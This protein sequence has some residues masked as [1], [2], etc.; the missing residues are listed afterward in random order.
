MS[1]AM[2]K[3]GGKP[4]VDG[5]GGLMRRL[6]VG[7]AVVG[8]G[9]LAFLGWLVAHHFLHDDDP[10]ISDQVTLIT[11]GCWVV[12]FMAGIGAF[13]GP[14]KWVLGRD[15]THED[16]MFLAG[17]DQ[18]VSR[19]FRFTT[20]HKVVGIQYLIVT[21]VLLAVGGT[22]AMMIRTDLI[23]PHSNFLGPQT[24]NAVVG[25]H[26]IIMIIATIV[27]VTG[28]FGNFI[29]PIMIGARDMAFPRLNALSLWL[30]VA[31]VPV[32]LSAAFLGGIPTG[33]SAYSPLSDQAPP[34]M[35]SYLVAIV[36][37]AISSA[38]A[39]ANITTTVLTMRARGMTWNRTPIF[40]YGTVASVGLALPALPMFMSAQVLLAVDRAM[41]GQFYVASG[42]GSPWLYQN[43]F[44]LFGHPEVYVIVIPAVVALME[45]TPVFA[46]KPLYN[47]NAAVLGIVGIVGL[48][49]MVWAHHMYASGWAPD[50]NGPFMLTTELISVPTGV[51]FLVVIGTIWRGRIWTTVPMMAVYA[52]LWN[53]IIGGVT[54]IYLSDVPA[55]YALHGSMFVTAHF[56]YTLMGAGLTGAIGALFYWFPKMTGRM[57]NERLAK[58]SFWTVQIGFNVVFLGMFAV[59]L[60]GQP[61]RVFTYA[62][63]FVVGNFVSSIGAYV[64]G[65][66][67]LLM[68]YTVI[69][70]WRNG[71]IAPA[72]PWGAKSLEWA[73][74][75]PIPLSNFEVLPVVVADAYGYGE[76][77][78][79]PQHWLEGPRHPDPEKV[80]AVAGATTTDDSD[81][82]TP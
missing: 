34:G 51:L 4:R 6:N 42:G 25:L 14:I 9:V 64:I 35:D 24:Y 63:T 43:L 54:G 79:T 75:N 50:L 7:S 30:L 69:S 57:Y 17:K 33:W 49:I 2:V 22:L 10:I 70:G 62:H 27:M 66:G 52:M 19:Y 67:M 55:D 47:F 29:L 41:G 61:R 77:D 44:W 76:G 78:L 20:D 48:S 56:H 15:L 59:G 72:N 46:R 82:A 13:N 53:F 40:V 73:V 18:G 3:L 36:V 26:G 21:M 31:A 12:G 65:L 45:L 81:G 74:P 8:G 16:E 1:E 39:G 28:P 11:M 71:P 60:A 38:V 23:S 58:I 5:G 80:G 37:F 68:L 32:L